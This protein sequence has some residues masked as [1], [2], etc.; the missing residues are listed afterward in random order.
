MKKLAVGVGVGVLGLAVAVSSNVMADN[1]SGNWYLGAN[2]G[3]YYLD[4]DRNRDGGDIESALVGGQLGYMTSNGWAFEAGSQNSFAADE[5]ERISINVI[6]MLSDTETVV[7]RP[8]V[9]SGFSRMWLDDHKNPGIEKDKTNQ[10]HLGMGL[11]KMLSDH[12]ELRGDLRL[13][14]QTSQTYY[15]GAATLAINYHFVQPAPVVAPAPEPEPV[16]V[17]PE[18]E[19]RTITIRLN[20]EFEFDS[21]KVRAIYGDELEAVAAAMKAHDDID[22]ALEGHTDSIG[23]EDYNQSLSERRAAAVK[24]K[25]VEDYGI[26]A[27]RISATGYGESRPIADNSTAEGRE[28]NRRVIGEMTYIEVV[29]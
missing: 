24:A 26:P 21:D 16:P 1:H 2:T 4:S 17:A 14:A 20:V 9:I 13:Q 10:I 29:E 27:D 25:L 5:V 28:K 6:K 7:G 22:L 19:K 11:S 23:N 8:Y 18:P 15:D 12:W 3:Y